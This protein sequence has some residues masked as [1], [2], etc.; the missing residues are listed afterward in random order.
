MGRAI[1]GPPTRTLGACIVAVVIAGLGGYY[2]GQ[3]TKAVHKTQPKSVAT[4]KPDAKPVR[5]RRV[6]EYHD[7]PSS[8]SQH[9][10]SWRNN[11]ASAMLEPAWPREPDMNVARKLAVACLPPDLFAA[12]DI[13]PFAQGDFHR[14][15]CISSPL[16]SVQYIMRV[17]LPVDPFFKTESEVATMHYIQRYLTLPIPAVVAYSSST[18][19][20]LGFEWILMEKINGVTVQS[21]WDDMSFDDK[22]RLTIEFAGHLQQLCRWR[23]PSLGSIYFSDVWSQVGYKPLSFQSPDADGIEGEFGVNGDYVIGTMVSTRFFS[24]KRLLLRSDRGPFQTSR[25]LIISE[26]NLVAQRIRHLSPSP[27]DDY[28]C[29]VD[30]GLINGGPEVFEVYDKFEKVV[31][32]VFPVQEG[33]APPEDANVLWH[34]DLSGLNV[35]IDPRTYK[36]LS[37]VDWESVSIV[38]AWET[39]GAIPGF[40]LGIEIE[41]EPPPLG[42]LSEE[43]EKGQTAIRKDWDLV[44]LRRKYKEIV[45]PLYNTTPDVEARVQLKQT[46]DELLS[47]FE[48]IWEHTRYFV[49]KEFSFP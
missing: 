4:A 10:A 28:Y 41:K 48:T 18:S 17:A 43:E 34:G 3:Q 44:L 16:T 14:L 7:A 25:D 2:F 6:T 24:E 27:G 5:P 42:S 30:Q 12:A 13:T 38:P 39:F 19:N 1:L 29:E 36:L 49:T 26:S 8:L 32:H 47:T 9:R 45:P 20:E 15:Y 37:I 23:F 35:M 33:P 11:K 46:V 31:R 40:L 22:S 21:V